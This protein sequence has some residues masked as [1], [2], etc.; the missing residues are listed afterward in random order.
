MSD[1][2]LIANFIARNGVTVC[3]PRTYAQPETPAGDGVP[4]KAGRELSYKVMRRGQRFRRAA[5][6]REKAAPK[7]A[8]RVE[9]VL[10]QIAPA[11]KPVEPAKPPKRDTRF[12]PSQ[13]RLDRRE[14]I[15]ELL[16]QG[17]FRTEEIAAALGISMRSA[18]RGKTEAR[19][20][21]GI[22]GRASPR[23]IDPEPILRLLAEGQTYDAIAT[24]TGYCVTTVMKAAHENGMRRR[25]RPRTPEQVAEVNRLRA[26]GLS[27]R[28]IAARCDISESAVG[29]ILL[30]HG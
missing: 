25:R 3:P 10:R 1:A 11:T 4:W 29:R 26:E 21:L 28:E 20:E 13:A 17:V 9:V 5:A 23:G 19:K 6:K 12:K 22:A 30:N 27:Y 2:D 18:R 8:P 16:T 7:P 24:S 15:G 14:R